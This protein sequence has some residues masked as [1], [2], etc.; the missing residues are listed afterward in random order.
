MKN[1]GWK[2][3]AIAALTLLAIAVTWGKGLKRGIDLSGGTILVYQVR[4]SSR[5]ESIKMDELITALKRRLNPEGVVDIPIRKIGNNRIE[6]ILAEATPEEVEDL[7]RKITQVGRLEFRILANEKKDGERGYNAIARAMSNPIK[8]PPA[9]Y[10][11]ARLGETT[12]GKNP[13]G[14]STHIIDPLRNWPRDRYVDSMVLLTGR[15]SVNK[16]TSEQVPIASNTAT[17]LTLKQPHHLLTVLSYTIE[18]NPSKERPSPDAIIRDQPVGNGVVERYILY[19]LDR[20]NVTGEMLDRIYPTQDERVQP[21]IGFIF[22]PTGARRFGTLTRDH[23]PEEGGAFRY[24]LAILLDGVVISDPT[25]N[26]EIRDSGIIEGVPPKEVTNLIEI[27][28]SGSLPTS[29]DPIPLLEEKIGPTLGQDTIDKGLRAIGISMIIVP[30]FMIVYYRF[31]GIVSVVAL[32]LNM[33]LLVAAMAATE[34]SFTLPGLAGL[35]LTIGMSVDANVLI[36]ERIREE[37]ERGASMIQQIRNGFDRAWT[38]IF[39][40]HITIFLSGIV[41][42]AVGTEEVR[43]FALT[44]IIGMIWNL[45]TAVWVS[46]VIFDFWYSRGWLRRVTMMKIMDKTNIDFIGPRKVLMTGSVVAIALGLAMFYVNRNR[47][48]NID[49]TGGTLVTIQLDNDAPDIKGLSEGRRAEYVREHA[50]NVLPDATVEMI[51]LGNQAHGVR[52]NIR[53]TDDRVKDVQKKILD[54][55]K[56][57]LLRLEVAVGPAV[58]IP[59]AAGDKDKDKD[60]DKKDKDKDKDKDKK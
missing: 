1:F 29:I 5:G 31:A 23:Q 12:T 44:L 27:L 22:N 49:F 11:W 36:F 34:S 50:G 56:T 30:L 17:T 33:I 53:T 37:Q 3:G 8:N 24:K 35:A 43:G 9:G 47:L 4:E 54:T 20:Q 39:D 13:K 25:L 10:R 16:E 48:F 15:D 18:Y 2:F 42:Y 6:I 46:R 38:T 51:K 21:A 52:F 40:S 59:A 26:A 28:R 14:D 32:V 57:T 58:P 55:F 60:K 41:L 19:K 45:L 7:K